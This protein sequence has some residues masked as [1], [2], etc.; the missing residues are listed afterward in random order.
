MKTLSLILLFAAAVFG[1]ERPVRGKVT[2]LAG[3]VVYVSLGRDAG[4]RDSIDLYVR[5]NSDTIATVRVFGFSSTSAA[6]RIITSSRPIR[7][8]DEVVGRI[9]SPESLKVSAAHDT[10]IARPASPVLQTAPGNTVAASPPPRALTVQGRLSAQYISF[11][12]SNAA[13]GVSQPGLVVDLRAKMNNAPVRLQFYGNLRSSA[14]GGASPF[15]S[16][17]R[18]LSR[19]YRASVE[20]D[21]GTTSVSLGRIIPPSAP[22]VGYTDGALFSR[23][24]G[25]ALFGAG[26]GFEP[27]FSGRTFSTDMKKFL[28][29]GAVSSDEGFRYSAGLAYAKRYFHSTLDREMASASLNLYPSNDLFVMSQTEVD[30]RSKSAESYPLKP[31]LTFLI[32]TLNYRAASFLSVG[33]GINSWRPSYAYSAIALLQDSLLDRDLRTSPN[34][35]ATLMLPG[36]LTV[37]DSYSPRSSPEGFGKEYLSTGW[38]SLSNAFRQ[39]ITLRGTMNISATTISTTRGYGAS[40]QKMFGDLAQV[41]FRYQWYHYAIAGSDADNRTKAVA[42]DLLLFLN[43]SFTLWGSF[44]RTT[45]TSADGSTLFTELSWRF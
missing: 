16:A 17:S 1:Q 45:E 42:L 2:Y 40:L 32:G 9:S 27:D 41:N 20:Y 11:R 36:G 31:R 4:V 21:D 37:S 26:G 18:N 3:D 29:F 22:A 39:A 7:I 13:A 10:S 30:L 5:V 38:I 8:D 44:E 23:R 14:A 33:A 43:R 28:L 15:S 6:C 24:F 12:Y 35:T 19:I 34:I 25:N